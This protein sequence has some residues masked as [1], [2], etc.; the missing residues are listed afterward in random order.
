[1]FLAMVIYWTLFLKPPNKYFRKFFYPVLVVLCGTLHA[2]GLLASHD[3]AESATLQ[4]TV[5]KAAPTIDG[6]VD[7]AEWADAAT[8]DEFFIQLEPEY[9]EP[10]PFRT[11]VHIGQTESALYVAFEAYDPDP[12][13]L[14]AASTQR[15]QMHE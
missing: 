4:I 8:I 15:D 13:R 5:L 9:G 7:A 11:V 2:V 10:S 3:P 6:E 12:L 14:A 1:M